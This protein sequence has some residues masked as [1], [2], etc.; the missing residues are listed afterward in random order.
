MH[1][2]TRRQKTLAP[3]CGWHDEP[4]FA[5][6][7]VPARLCSGLAIPYA[8]QSAVI[9]KAAPLPVSQREPSGQRV[10]TGSPH[11]TRPPV[12]FIENNTDCPALRRRRCH[13]GCSGEENARAGRS[14][15]RR[16]QPP[17]QLA[18]IRHAN[19]FTPLP[20]D[21][22]RVGGEGRLANARPD[23][24]SRG[25]RASDATQRRAMAPFQVLP[26]HRPPPA[27]CSRAAR[28][29]WL[30]LMAARHQR[31]QSLWIPATCVARKSR[32]TISLNA[33][34]FAHCGCSSPTRSQARHGNSP[35]VPFAS[36]ICTFV[37]VFSQAAWLA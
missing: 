24:S 25:G 20:S 16:S 22:G 28:L 30:C 11:E 21:F 26:A 29:G 4:A 9:F 2:P 27:M 7:L 13:G 17:R 5:T 37:R 8:R 15:P 35:C 33:Q 31:D 10:P 19:P 1:A 18:G 34:Q 32:L 14:C 6:V 3:F 36:V 12:R 23:M